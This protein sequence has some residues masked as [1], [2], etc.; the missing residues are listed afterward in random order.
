V[1]NP[2]KWKQARFQSV[3]PPKPLLYAAALSARDD[4]LSIGFPEEMLL[5]EGDALTM[6]IVGM[7]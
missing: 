7:A 1:G 6:V 4:Q 2:R 5:R 3:T